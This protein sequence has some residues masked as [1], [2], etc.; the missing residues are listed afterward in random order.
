MITIDMMNFQRN[1]VSYGMSSR[2]ST[3]RTLF[4]ISLKEIPAN[5]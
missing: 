5:V 1:P 2:P 4:T 3:L